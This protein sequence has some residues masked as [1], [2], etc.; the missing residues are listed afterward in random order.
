MGRFHHHFTCS[1][2]THISQKRKKD[3]QRLDCIVCIF[4]ICACTSFE[5]NVGE[6]D[7]R[8]LSKTMMR[9]DTSSSMKSL[10]KRE[11]ERCIFIR[12]LYFW[13]LPPS[14]SLSLSLSL[15]LSPFFSIYFLLTH[16]HSHTLSAF[17]YPPTLSLS[18]TLSYSL[19]IPLYFSLS[20][21]RILGEVVFSFAHELKEVSAVRHPWFP[22]P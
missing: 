13:S 20:F 2:C 10:A 21:S 6:I 3:R 4:G 17:L 19:F 9:Y 7:P 12:G 11:R 8:R 5:K 22:C 18:L 15:C 1:F 14:L 16:L